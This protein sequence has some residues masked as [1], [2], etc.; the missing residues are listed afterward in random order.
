MINN[1]QQD[2]EHYTTCDIN[3]ATTLIT[4]KYLMEGVDYAYE[5]EKN[6][7]TAFFKFTNSEDL[8]RTVMEYGQGRLA[9]EPKMF[10]SNY[11]YIRAYITEKF[12]NPN[13]DFT[14]EKR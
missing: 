11:R 1:T 2:S 3:L 4:L 5:G 14:E 13:N 8:D 7:P 12:R 6:R 10:M 9:V